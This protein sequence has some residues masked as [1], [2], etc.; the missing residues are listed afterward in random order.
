MEYTT[1]EIIIFVASAVAILA[2]LVN[3]LQGATGTGL[4]VSVFVVMMF[5][6]VIVMTAKKA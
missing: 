3:I 6:I 2:S 5:L 4:W 1:R